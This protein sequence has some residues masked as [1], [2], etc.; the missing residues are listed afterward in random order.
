MFWKGVVFLSSCA[1]RV[2]KGDGLQNVELC[3]LHWL[4]VQWCWASCE[5][6]YLDVKEEEKEDTDKEDTI[7]QQVDQ[8]DIGQWQEVAEQDT[9]FLSAAPPFLPPTCL[10]Q[11]CLGMY[12]GWQMLQLHSLPNKI[13]PQHVC[14]VGCKNLIT[15]LL[16]V[17]S[18]ADSLRA[19]VNMPAI[20]CLVSCA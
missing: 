3:A 19:T 2:W 12:V 10:A 14:A 1:T 20:V 13:M 16:S 4:Q 6:D 9:S 5:L 8:N 7:S 15:M 17:I 11:P 18:S